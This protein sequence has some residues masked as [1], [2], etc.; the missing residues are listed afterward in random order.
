MPPDGTTAKSCMCTRSSPELH[1]VVHQLDD[2]L[3]ETS[4]RRLT[5]E[6]KQGESDQHLNPLSVEGKFL[7]AFSF[8]LLS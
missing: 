5:E 2:V 4:Y 3:D 8:A 7:Q 1:D 6:F